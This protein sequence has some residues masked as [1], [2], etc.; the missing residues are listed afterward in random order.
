[1]AP[2]SK[3]HRIGDARIALH[4]Q[5]GDLRKSLVTHSINSRGR[6]LGDFRHDVGF[7][8]LFRSAR[9]AMVAAAP[10]EVSPNTPLDEQD[11]AGWPNDGRVPPL[12]L[13]RLKD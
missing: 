11:L 9:K 1:M 3:Q 4:L 13:Q 5:G 2:M 6:P 8:V 12:A 7:S 10:G